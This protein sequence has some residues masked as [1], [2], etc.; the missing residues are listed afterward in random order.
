MALVRLMWKRYTGIPEKHS[1]GTRKE[2]SGFSD[3]SMC[4]PL[5]SPMPGKILIFLSEKDFMN[6]LEN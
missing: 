6:H 5:C 2:Q 4:F 3:P 1:G